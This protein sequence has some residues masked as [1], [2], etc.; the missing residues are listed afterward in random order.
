MAMACG[1]VS[2]NKR[3]L[4][5]G[6]FIW[7]KP[8]ECSFSITQAQWDWLI[9][10]VDSHRAILPNALSG[11]CKSA[12]GGFVATFIGSAACPFTGL[13]SRILRTEKLLETQYLCWL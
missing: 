4:H 7:P 3:R 10:G 9:A 1:C 6:H 5:Q 8:G 13:I 12:P 2:A 11:I